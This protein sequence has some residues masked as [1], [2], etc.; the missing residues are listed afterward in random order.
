MNALQMLDII[1]RDY[2]VFEDDPHGRMGN[3]LA[4]HLRAELVADAEWKAYYLKLWTAG[5]PSFA[6]CSLTEETK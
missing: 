3:E 2:C 5:K 6:A 4:G 1:L